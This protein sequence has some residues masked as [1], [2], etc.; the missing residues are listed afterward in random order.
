MCS[1]NFIV[2]DGLLF[3]N[4]VRATL[5]ITV[6][7]VFASTYGFASF[8]QY[9]ILD[10]VTIGNFGI[11]EKFGSQCRKMNSSEPVKYSIYMCIKEYQR[12]EKN[13]Q[14]R[15]LVVDAIHMET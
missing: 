1:L 3:L 9:S 13:L 12:F 4:A 6:H 14:N 8:L 5:L 2:A 10:D 11:N 15:S 7:M